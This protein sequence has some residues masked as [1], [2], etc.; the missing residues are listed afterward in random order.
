MLIKKFPL[1]IVAFPIF[2]H[3]ILIS[4]IKVSSIHLDSLFRA[5]T[6]SSLVIHKFILTF[7]LESAASETM[8]HEE[9][10]RSTMLN[11][12]FNSLAHLH[13][14]IF[15]YL[16]FYYSWDTRLIALLRY[17]WNFIFANLYKPTS[18]LQYLLAANVINPYALIDE[19]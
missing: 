15:S 11:N 10:F 18:N 4:G 9:S 2:P 12:V 14:A 5:M 7:E 16:K 17:L 13:V 3:E 8:I 19:K 6:N 1:D